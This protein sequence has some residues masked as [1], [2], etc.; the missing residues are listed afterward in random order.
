LLLS[1]ALETG[2]TFAGVMGRQV[3][4]LGVFNAF[5]RQFRILA[6]VDIFFFTKIIKKKEHIHSSIQIKT[7]PNVERMRN[8]NQSS[9]SHSLC[10]QIIFRIE[11][12][13]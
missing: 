10:M 1:V 11:S 3:A 7:K 5:S 4:A 12:T 6:L 2:F 8:L 13:I 9:P